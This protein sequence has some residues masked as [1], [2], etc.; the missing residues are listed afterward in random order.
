MAAEG[1]QRRGGRRGECRKGSSERGMEEGIKL[2]REGGRMRTWRRKRRGERQKGT[3]YE[4][5]E[6]EDKE[7]DGEWRR[8]SEGKRGRKEWSRRRI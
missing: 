6:E 1:S 8:G 5:M 7:G 2:K 4:G 3:E